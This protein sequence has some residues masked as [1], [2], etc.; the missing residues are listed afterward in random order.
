MKVGPLLTAG[1]ILLWAWQA[2]LWWFAVPIA[3]A[4]EGSRFTSRRW[5]FDGTDLQRLWNLCVV[6]VAGCAVYLLASVEDGMGLAAA[7]TGARNATP[8][9]D[10][11]GDAFRHLV[12]WFPLCTA[13]MALAAAWGRQETLPV[14][15]FSWYLRR[16]PDIGT[17]IRIDWAYLVAVLAGA[18]VG[19]FAPAFT[20]ALLGFAAVLF[21][22]RRNR[23]LPRTMWLAGI[24]VGFAAALLGPGRLQPASAWWR[25]FEARMLARLFQRDV[26]PSESRTSIGR[27]GVSKGSG[28]IVFRI[29]TSPTNR[30]VELLRDTAYA[31]YR[32]G[33]WQNPD[34][35][36]FGDLT[37]TTGEGAFLF[38]PETNRVGTLNL[39][40]AAGRRRLMPTPPG[41]L[42]VGPIPADQLS[43]NALGTLLLSELSFG[44]VAVHYGREPRPL[45]APTDADLGVPEVEAAALDKAA[46]EAGLAWGM[47]GAEVRQRL[48]TFFSGRFRYALYR[49]TADRP[50]WT[51]STLESFLLKD[52]KGHCEYFG[53][54]TTLLFR[55]L[56]VP[57]RYVVGWSVPDP[58]PG[59]RWI[60]VRQRHAHAWT[61]AWIDGAWRDVDTTPPSWEEVEAKEAAWW[62]PFRD[63]WN[64]VVF[65]WNRLRNGVTAPQ[66]WLFGGIVLVGA[67]LAFQVI[68][69]RLGRTGTRIQAGPAREIPGA[70]SE[71]YEVVGRLERAGHERREGE[72]FAA[73]HRRLR[74]NAPDT[75]ESVAPLLAL[76]Y[77]LRFDPEGLPEGPRSD[78]RR[79]VGDWMLRGP[80]KSR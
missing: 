8:S 41:L 72:T 11:A 69:R 4:L 65:E 5:D 47:K 48:E 26:N 30:P 9:A 62:E 59:G 45:P 15:V 55:R 38:G 19:D 35:A 24:A 66:L 34:G 77:R 44:P 60:P 36:E 6:A 14:S 50:A 3:L 71:F 16:R 56:G 1:A 21:W 70:D 31:A 40:L 25:D 46:T 61:L 2:D 80:G 58:E 7:A 78:L 17:A 74:E 28:A 79:S 39:W 67:W 22:F 37:P 63:G 32:R 75:A 12:Q 18:C 73:W 52:R 27:L 42:G 64:R 29:E 57:A 53:T 51:N 10:R 13:P 49:G 68:R 76:H 20:G 54:A 33:V 43:T 23:G